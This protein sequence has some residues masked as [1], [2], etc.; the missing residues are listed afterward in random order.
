MAKPQPVLNRR[1]VLE[2][3]SQAPD[4]SGGFIESWV[5]LGEIWAEVKAGTGREEAQDALSLAAVPYRITVR[6]APAG[7]PSRPRAEQRFREGGRVFRILAVA[8]VGT[9]GRFLVCHTREE[10]IVA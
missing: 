7:W 10:E 1:L 8:D 9:D 2:K 4:G 3:P 6:A 5:P